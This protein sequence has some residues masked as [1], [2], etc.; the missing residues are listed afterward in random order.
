MER[1][2]GLVDDGLEELVPRLGRGCQARHAMEEAELL[3]LPR[4]GILDHVGVGHGDHDTKVRSVAGPG[5]CG[6]VERTLRLRADRNLR[7]TA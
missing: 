1:V 7:E 3:E 6:R 5:G 2:T 4:P